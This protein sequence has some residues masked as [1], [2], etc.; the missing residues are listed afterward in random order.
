ME[1]AAGLEPAPADVRDVRT[2]AEALPQRTRWFE[3]LSPAY[4]AR[5]LLASATV[6]TQWLRSAVS[7]SEVGMLQT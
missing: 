2:G 4:R 7:V 3:L 5:T 6:V 1:R